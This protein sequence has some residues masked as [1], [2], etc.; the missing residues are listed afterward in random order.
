MR[1]LTK[2]DL[3]ELRETLKAR[4]LD[5]WLVFDFHGINPVAQRVVGFGAMVTRRVFA[6]FPAVGEPR[7]LVH[8]I[9][10]HAVQAFPGAVEV[11]TR[12]SELHQRLGLLV[13][14]RRLAME[15]SPEDAV[16]YLDRVPLGITELLTRLGATLVPSAP[17]VTR[18]A[19]RWSPEELSQ[20]RQVAESL[21]DIARRT[22]AATIGR[23]G[24][25]RE[26]AVEEQ[27]AAAITQAGWTVV[28]PPIVAFGPNAADP[29]YAPGEAHDAVLQDGDVVLL[30]LWARHGPKGMWAD[31]TWMGFAGSSV[32]DDVGAAWTAVRDARDAV[33]DRLRQA[34]RAGESVTGAELDRVA[35]GVIERRGYGEAF[36][37]RTGHSIDG[38]LH[39]S[40]PHLDDFETY[41]IRELMPGVGFSVEPGVYLTGRFGVRSEVNVY[42]GAAGPVVTPNDV[43]REMIVRA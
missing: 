17:L 37:H 7:V 26:R 40:G 25:A 35:R 21:A 28:D 10:R 3:D 18:F 41:D 8:S 9:D 31:Q 20:H 38:D 33:L 39:G 1:T 19:A 16:P 14:G 27:V 15:I 5:G 2:A 32:P 22:I 24:E 34:A 23:P 29:H 30:D 36:V 4:R 13:R 42:W 6:L 11:Y 12:W 43:Q